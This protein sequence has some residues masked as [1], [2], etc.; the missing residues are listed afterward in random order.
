MEESGQFDHQPEIKSAL[1][2]S[3]HQR[4]L[5]ESLTERDCSLARMYLGTI[6]VLESGNSNQFAL[7]A[8]GIRELIEKLP[9]SLEVDQ[10]SQKQHLRSKV[11]N[12]AEDWK[13]AKK[14]SMCHKIGSW[15]GEI[16]SSLKRFLKRTGEFIDWFDLNRPTRNRETANA[17]NALDPARPRLP[18]NLE[19]AYVQVWDE[20]RD[21]FIKVSH[22]RYE[23]SSPEFQQWLE[24][25]ERFLLERLRPRTFDDAEALDQLIALGEAHD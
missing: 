17:L 19:V 8:H 12:I 15:N 25:L 20:F 11:G 7:A 6:E 10:P 18:E 16:D 4:A 13:R 2:L 1:K 5:L 24:E 21:F 23:P 22:H 3:G 9:S 14:N